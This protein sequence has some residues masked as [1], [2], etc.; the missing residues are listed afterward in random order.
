MEIGQTV[1]LRFRDSLSGVLDHEITG[2][3][4]TSEV[5]DISDLTTYRFYDAELWSV[6]DGIESYRASVT[7]FELER[8]GYGSNYGYDY[9]ENDGS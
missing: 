8:L 7:T 3:T 1:T 4:G 9:G 2:L 6:R 5:V